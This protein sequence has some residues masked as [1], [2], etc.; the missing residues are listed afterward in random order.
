MSISKQERIRIA[1]LPAHIAALAEKYPSEI[2]NVA[3]NWNNPCLPDSY[4]PSIVEVYCNDPYN[5]SIYILDGV[6]QRYQLSAENEQV[7]AITLMMDGEFVY[8]EIEGQEV[9][10]KM[11]NVP[12]P[13]ILV[14]PSCL[15]ISLFAGASDD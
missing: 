15:I 5:S 7:P 4:I 13:E 14:N 3:D 2:V 6:L 12:F 10:N 11:G 1:K 8:I 9:F